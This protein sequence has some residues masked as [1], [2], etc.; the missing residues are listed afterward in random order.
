MATGIAHEINQPLNV[1]RIA[2]NMIQESIADNENDP[3]F[4]SARADKILAMVERAVRIINQL[5]TFGRKVDPNLKLIDA[6]E[7]IL[8]AVDL[9]REKL[10]L[11][12]IT[13]T[14]Y[15]QDDLPPIEGNTHSLE[16]VYLNLI[17]NSVDVLRR[18]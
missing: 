6:N 8:S 1:I 11:S 4:V 15:L 12:S 10:R 3:V 2:A 14:L 17:L 18:A 5:R 7:A 9:V 16:Q 13:L